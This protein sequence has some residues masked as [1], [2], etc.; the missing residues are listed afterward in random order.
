MVLGEEAT[1]PG[2]AATMGI[3]RVPGGTPKRQLHTCTVVGDTL[4]DP[5]VSKSSPFVT[6]GSYP[7][8]GEDVLGKGGQHGLQDGGTGKTPNPHPLGHTESVP[9][10]KQLLLRKARG[11]WA[12]KSHRSRSAGTS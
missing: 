6:D 8:L 7:R 9:V 10:R 2:P 4:G 1:S 5:G 3:R 11:S 12:H